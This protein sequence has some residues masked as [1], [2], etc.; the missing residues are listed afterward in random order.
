M[1]EITCSSITNLIAD[2]CI[3][4]ATQLPEALQSCIRACQ[5]QEKSPV[6]QGVF[7]DMIANFTIAADKRLPI[8]QDTGMAVVFLRIGQDVHIVGGSLEEAVNEGVRRGYTEGFLRKS[9]VSDPLRR[10]NTNDNTPAV[11]HT[12]LIPGDGFEVTVAPKGFGSEN[13][14]AMRLF[15]PSA[16]QEDVVDFLVET[17]SNA[18]SNPCPPVILGVGLGGTIEQAA[19]EAKRA[20]LR[21]A[22]SAN[23]DPFYNEMEREALR[24][25]NALG[26]GPQ[27]F[28]GSVTALAVHITPMATHIAGL[29]CVVN[30]G[31]HVTRH[32]KGVL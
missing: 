21:E 32:A 19:L 23:P 28:G 26:I 24:R 30:T 15:T 2:L 13:M 7:Q 6:G 11:L 9:V 18:S 5:K 8:C 27:G 29:P 12:E 10:V 31:C 14:S 22:G 25:I 4:A 1:R 20:L 16:T 17:V 3:E